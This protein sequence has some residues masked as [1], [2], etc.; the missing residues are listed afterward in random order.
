MSAASEV[1][2]R[3]GFV[4]AGRQLDDLTEPGTQRLLAG[5]HANRLRPSCL[6]TDT[7]V[8]MYIA[9]VGTDRYVIKRMPDTGMV[10]APA[11][12]SYLPPEMVSG[13]GQVLGGAIQ[14][15]AETGVTAL[16]LGF[17]M[18]KAER[19][20]GAATQGAT[21]ADSVATD[22]SRLTLLA[23]L[24]YLWQ[25][26]GLATWSPAMT[27][28][29]NWGVVS[30][31]LR[32][33]ARGKFTKGKPLTTRLFIPEPFHADRK[34]ELAARRLKAWSPA[35]QVG[36]TS[37]FMIAIG[38]VKAIEEARF[39]HKLII[40]HMPDAPVMLADDLHRRMLRR[41]SE[42]LELWQMDER[43]HL[44]VIATFALGR[45]RLATAQELSLSVTDER[46]L[47][48]ESLADKL[49]LDA[50]VAQQRRFTKSLRYNLDPAAPMASLVLTDTDSPTAVYLVR[51]GELDDTTA[52]ED[53][54]GVRA[55]VWACSESDT[56]L[57]AAR[58]T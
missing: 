34:A 20:A 43:G 52:L 14:E 58:S 28:K 31:H 19:N 26:A 12:P 6:C 57:P 48:Y 1:D 46:W 50:A 18:G 56:S 40:K 35:R 32:Q 39:G 54:T 41:F 17:R 53:Q 49:L 42:E 33:A 27:G 24:H 51:N 38:E 10:H 47:P 30:W 25:E 44:L 9:R 37:Q 2:P 36:R 45:G 29:R 3:Q 23:M 16:K 55:W 15:S 5:A 11:C 8:E 21:E 7:G 13:L 4:L 22:G